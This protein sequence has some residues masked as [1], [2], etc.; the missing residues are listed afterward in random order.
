[1]PEGLYLYR[2]LFCP[3]D[4]A[5]LWYRKRLPHKSWPSWSLPVVIQPQVT[6]SLLAG[7]GVQDG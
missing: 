1:M 4:G 7:S 2:R 3:K 6:A 5:I